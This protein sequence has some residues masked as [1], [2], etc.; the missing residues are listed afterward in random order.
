MEVI[1]ITQARV[2]STRL[3]G[4][5]LKKIN[6]Q[7]LLQIH[8]SRLKKS[9]L[10]SKIIVATTFEEGVEQIVEIGKVM[11]VDV[12]QGSTD[13]V[14]DRFFQSV[15]EYAPD[16]VVRVTSDCPLIDANLIDQVIDLTINNELD[17]AANILKEL[18]PDG[19]DVEVVSFNTLK[20]AWEEAKLQSDREHVTPF[21]RRNT[22]F[23]GGDLFKA[24]NLDCIKNYNQIRMTVDEQAD[25]DAM[26]TLINDLGLNETWETYT[27]HILKHPD[28]FKNQSIFRNEGYLKSLEKEK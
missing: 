15:K 19:Q 8:L 16:Y 24:Q 12:F 3:P 10:A 18:Y 20:R 25:F 13:D 11:S 28:R 4:K 26:E 6:N 5:V 14:L 2:G 21:I 23:M 27:Q 9:K 22:D 7:S 17:Y 1:I